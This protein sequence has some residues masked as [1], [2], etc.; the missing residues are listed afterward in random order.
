MSHAIPISH[1]M[2]GENIGLEA[3]DDGVWNIYFG[4]LELGRFDERQRR[5]IDRL[6]KKKRRERRKV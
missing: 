2:A 3:V 4:H 6:G 1:T 5:V